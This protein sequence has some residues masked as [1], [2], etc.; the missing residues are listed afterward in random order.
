MLSVTGK[1][2]SFS[3]IVDVNLVGVSED[4]QLLNLTMCI[5]K[6]PTM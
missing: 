1:T 3:H 4:V 6:S 2:L 5:Q